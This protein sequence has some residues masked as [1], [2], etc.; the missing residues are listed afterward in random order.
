M[1]CLFVSVLISVF[2]D[3]IRGT[4][5][6]KN[7]TPERI[8]T[9][10]TI[11]TLSTDL[12]IE[13]ETQRHDS[14]HTFQQLVKR[15][16]TYSQSTESPKYELYSDEWA[17]YYYN[18]YYNFDYDYQDFDGKTCLSF[19]TC[20]KYYKF[21]HTLSECHCDE[22]CVI[23][24]DC[25]H[26]YDITSGAM[27]SNVSF[28]CKYIPGLF[29][30]FVFVINTCPDGTA[31]DLNT[32]CT[33]RDE[34]NI[35]SMTPTSD[36]NTGFFYQNVYCA[37]CNGVQDFVLWKASY[38]CSL[39]KHEYAVLGNLTI[40]ELYLQKKCYLSYI[41]P[42]P[43]VDFRWCFP[44]ISSCPSQTNESGIL[45][46]QYDDQVVSECE[47]G[48][49]K[50]IF[51]PDV[52]YEN[53]ACYKC[54]TGKNVTSDSEAS[55]DLNTFN[56]RKFHQPPRYRGPYSI[57]VLF[58]LSTQQSMVKRNADN[59]VTLE[60]SSFS[61]KCELG[62]SYDPFNGV[63]Q[64]MCNKTDRN[65]TRR[66]HDRQLEL[67]TTASKCSFLTIKKSEF[68]LV[69]NALIIHHASGKLSSFKN[70]KI[71]ENGA[72]I[73]VE[74][75]MG[76]LRHKTLLEVDDIFHLSTNG[77]S[78]I[79]L[80]ATILIYAKTSLHK[81]PGKCLLCLSLSLLVSQSMLLVAPVAESNVVW[82]K[83]ASLVMH[84]SFMASF[85][86][87]NVMA[88]DVYTSFTQHF[89]YSGIHNGNHLFFKYSLYAWLGPFVIVTVAFL[90]DEFSAWE[91]RPK[92]GQSFC[93]ITESIGLLIFFLGPLALILLT[94]LFFFTMAMKNICMAYRSRADDVQ[95][96]KPCEI[97]VYF[98]L[99]VIM[100]LT[101]VFAFLGNVVNDDIFW[102]LFAVSNGLQGLLIFM[103]FALIPLRKLLYT[104]KNG[105]DE[106]TKTNAQ[107]ITKVVD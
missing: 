13:T 38:Q 55:C 89:R 36:L 87:M 86:W 46:L 92:C 17:S 82:C 5:K 80:L 58:D 105:N 106:K 97:F 4:G 63:C 71:V 45:S 19:W 95:R 16:G 70:F 49:N 101:W 90:I 104:G 107:T 73:C 1:I 78:I 11:S 9:A 24:K 77:L 64:N 91:I 26:N 51:T 37:R 52:I 20:I 75:T 23:Y 50:Y 10:S 62:E 66:R 72:T 103:G 84:Y 33:Q 3:V 60:E 41:P 30:W 29:S 54:N 2:S 35:Y 99:S 28:D 68:E 56:I 100:G 93:W 22:L 53:L 43:N 102:T 8:D 6:E 67:N 40:Q 96:R 88:F 57:N 12:N 25:C 76:V 31:D 85:T 21:F 59:V 14:S 34:N 81:L 69:N 83:A 48:G 74:N 15:A 79:S 7:T 27:K 44:R 61:T 65:C 18:Y 98:K 32:L 47:N 42:L 94:N 39:K